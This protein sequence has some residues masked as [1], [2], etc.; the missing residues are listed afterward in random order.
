MLPDPPVKPSKIEDGIPQNLVQKKLFAKEASKEENK[1]AS[2]EALK[3][4]PK[5]ALKEAPEDF[6]PESIKRRDENRVSIIHE[7]EP[8]ESV[9]PLIEMPLLKPSE[10][11]VSNDVE[12]KSDLLA[13]I[14]KK[15][16]DKI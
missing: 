3:E 1:N 5:E 14:M 8:K 15:K 2:K 4:A 13:R 6:K 12:E 11:K 10:V 7:S 16:Q 9:K